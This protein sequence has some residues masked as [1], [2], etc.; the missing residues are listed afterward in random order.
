MKNPF[1]GGTQTNR[2]ARVNSS[3]LLVIVALSKHTLTEAL[4]CYGAEVGDFALQVVAVPVTA[5]VFSLDFA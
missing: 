2:S 5:I 3:L 1:S 4:R